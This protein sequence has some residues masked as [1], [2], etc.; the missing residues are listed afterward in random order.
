LAVEN[1]LASAQGNV[2]LGII[3]VYRTLGGGWQ[4]REGRDVLSDE[5]K[6]APRAA[7]ST[8]PT[9]EPPTKG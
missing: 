4:I 3:S 2:V 9:K 5:V 6:A 7:A 8:E 1:S